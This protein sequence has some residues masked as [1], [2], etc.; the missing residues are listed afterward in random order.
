MIPYIQ[1]MEV[2]PVAGKDSMLLNLSGAHAPYFTRNIVI[3]TDSQ[4]NTGVGEVPGGQKIT[5]ALEDVRPVV[6]GSKISAYK[7]T[8]LKVKEAL[9]NDESDVRGLQ[10][11]DLRTGIHVVTAIEAPLLDLLGQ[12]LEVPVASL[13]GD[14]MIRDR[15]KV[16]GY[17][18]F[19]GDRK[20]TDLPYY[21][22]EKNSEDWYRLRHDEA[23][24]ADAVVELARSSQD[25]YGFKDFKLKGG[26]LEGK[27]EIEVI[28]TLKKA[29]P[30]ARMTL[31]PNGG[32]SLK[33]AIGLCKDMHGI[34]TYCEDPC[35]AEQG[36]SGREVLSEFRRATGLPT[37]TNMIATDWRQFG[38]S[39]ELQSVDIPLA[40]CHFWTM[41]GAVRVGQLCD[42]FGLTW[43]SHSNNHFDISLAMIAHVGA[44]VPGNPTAIDTHW[45][46]QEGIERLSLKPMKIE[47]GHIALTDRP[48][49]GIE[50]DR[51]QIE[52]AHKLY[53][54]QNL[55]ARDD[56]QGMQFLIPGW[57]FDP[58]RPALVR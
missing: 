37:A 20:K 26:V 12:Y 18:F 58:K 10:T 9:G 21:Y 7:Q 28:K 30:D 24:D 54:E 34:L 48:G 47:D 44:A 31:D 15:V 33:E 46:W 43:G 50:V 51:S 17:L 40:D 49:L 39:L 41:S 36:Y 14:G 57:K 27:K 8:L 53:V 38:H 4:G 55:G 23:L 19:I 2:F 22:D 1:K 16:L 32:W 56:A 29:Y 13:L 25:L 45:I 11:F 5:K 6:E 35:G 3:L 42:E 52:K